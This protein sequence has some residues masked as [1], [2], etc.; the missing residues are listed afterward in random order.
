MLSCWRMTDNAVDEV[1]YVPPP[2]PHTGEAAVGLALA[3]MSCLTCWIPALGFFVNAPAMVVNENA[4]KRAK[5]NGN[6]WPR[7]SQ[8]ALR[9][10]VG[11]FLVTLV[12]TAGIPVAALIMAFFG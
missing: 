4:V 12:A 1:Q 2:K 7:M 3:I 8:I 5:L 6:S 9:M 11:A 10:S